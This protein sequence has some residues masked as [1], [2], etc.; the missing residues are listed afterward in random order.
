MPGC[1]NFR[2]IGSK[3]ST[4]NCTKAGGTD[5]YSRLISDKKIGGY[6]KSGKYYERPELKTWKSYFQQNN[7][8]FNVLDENIFITDPA[9]TSNDINIVTAESIFSQE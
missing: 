3:R 4:D 9:E 2:S 7:F 6:N 5:L 8:Q 1:N